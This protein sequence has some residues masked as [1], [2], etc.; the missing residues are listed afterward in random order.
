MADFFYMANSVDSLSVMEGAPRSLTNGDIKTLAYA[1]LGIYPLVDSELEKVG[2]AIT[3]KAL[4][5][6]IAA[7]EVELDG[8][9]DLPVVKIDDNAKPF[10]YTYYKAQEKAEAARRVL[11]SANLKF[12]FPIVVSDSVWLTQITGRGLTFALNKPD[13]NGR[14]TSFFRDLPKGS[15]M[16]NSTTLAFVPPDPDQQ[17]H[18]FNSLQSVGEYT[19]PPID[20]LQATMNQNPQISGGLITLDAIQRGVIETEQIEI[21]LGLLVPGLL[22]IIPI[23]NLAIS[24]DGT[25]NPVIR[26]GS[27]GVVPDRN[28]YRRE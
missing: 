25:N 12:P 5:G 1:E 14:L 27:L 18:Y 23:S 8:G 3:V 7:A 19:A 13:K 28:L 6:Q 10:L 22:G 17:I 15:A 20:R 24:A 11:K 4:K 2:S 16:Y 9:V 21:G 26:L